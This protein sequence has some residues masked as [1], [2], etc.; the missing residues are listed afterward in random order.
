MSAGQFIR[1]VATVGLG[2]GVA[3]G[4]TFLTMPI[5]T[6]LYAPDAYA[7]WAILVSVSLIFSS[8]ATLRFELAVVLPH[9][10]EDAANLACLC[11]LAALMVSGGAAGILSLGSRTIIGE[12][13]HPVLKAWLWTIPVL[14][15]L[16]A[17]YQ[18]ACAWCVRAKEFFAYS[19]AQFLLPLCTVGV[20]MYLGW[21]RP[22]GVEGLVIGTVVG[23]TLASLVMVGFVGGKHGRRIAGSLRPGRLAAMFRQ[24]ANYPLYM[25][26][27]TIVGTLRERLAYL[28]LGNFGDKAAV[29]Y[30]GL[31]SRVVSMPNSFVASAVRPVFFQVAARTGFSSMET[32]II[33]V[34]RVIIV[35]VTPAWTFFLFKA[36]DILALV[37]GE[38]W[39]PAGPYAA[40]LSVAA[41]PLLLGNWLDRGF[42]VLGRQ[43]LAFML[44]LVFSGISLLALAAGVFVLHD[45]FLAIV[46]QVAALTVYYWFWLFVLFSAA[47][48]RRSSLWGLLGLYAALTGVGSLVAFVL[49]A[50]LPVAA[51]LCVHMT[52]ALGA[53]LLF[54]RG[55]LRGLRAREA[56]A[57]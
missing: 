10:D 33:R 2:G 51:A 45:L 16:T 8:V 32:H 38:L 19:L 15:A 52:I 17:L 6:R 4:L 46:L 50:S 39:R 30:Y 13:F 5:I 44:E 22:A 40:V 48:F 47:G 41:V 24:Y 43:R 29:G 28:W 20:Q 9:E 53:A 26:P 23:Q 14:I 11:L 1:R 7:G 21:A 18:T 34:L 57:T 31:S 42:D 56:N 27:Y 12:A 54:L 35:I 49:C 55:Q 3:Q 25:T 37:F 36:G